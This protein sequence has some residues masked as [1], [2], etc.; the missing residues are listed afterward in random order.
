MTAKSNQITKNVHIRGFGILEEVPIEFSQDIAPEDE[1]LE[2]SDMSQSSQNRG[3]YAL[4]IP[5]SLN[6]ND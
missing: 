4:L 5:N 1:L 3:N 2:I 6:C